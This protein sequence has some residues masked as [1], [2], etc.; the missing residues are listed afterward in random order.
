MFSSGIPRGNSPTSA[1]N[2]RVHT[3]IPRNNLN[4]NE[5][6]L[7]DIDSPPISRSLLDA[8]R[9]VNGLHNELENALESGDHE[10]VKVALDHGA[11][12][13]SY[14]STRRETLL[15]TACFNSDTASLIMLLQAG[16]DP[17]QVLP[18]RQSG[19]QVTP[20]MIAAENGMTEAVTE[21]LRYKA[22]PHTRNLNGETA[23]LAAART[24]NHDT[25]AALVGSM[26]SSTAP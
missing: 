11:N 18:G 24:N 9:D 17:N 1:L 15:M 8:V 3:Y 14:H 25:F 2:A 23:L 10:R 19:T 20:L 21:L 12:P 6:V 4:L 5:S 7:S 13:N 16:A 26:V 22:D